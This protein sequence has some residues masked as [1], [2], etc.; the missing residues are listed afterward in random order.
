MYSEKWISVAIVR[1][2]KFLMMSVRLKSYGR[3]EPI[4]WTPQSPRDSFLSKRLFQR[5]LSMKYERD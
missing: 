5:N 2:K 1:E 4:S 3:G